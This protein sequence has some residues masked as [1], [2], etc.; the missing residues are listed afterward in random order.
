MGK[1]KPIFDDRILSLHGVKPDVLY[2]FTDNSFQVGEIK[3]Y[4]EIK[5]DL[6]F[7]IKQKG[8]T[9]LDV[10]LDYFVKDKSN[11]ATSRLFD[12]QL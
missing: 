2:S 11:K 5:F 4:T 8:L 1:I 7:K 9:S 6:T 3:S 10:E 12:G